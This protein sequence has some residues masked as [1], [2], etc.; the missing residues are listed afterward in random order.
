[1]RSSTSISTGFSPSMP[2]VASPEGHLAC[3]RV[4]QPSVLVVG[5]IR[6]RGRDLLNV[7]R[8]QVEHPLR[9]EPSRA[10]GNHCSNGVEAGAVLAAVGHTFRGCVAAQ[11]GDNCVSRSRTPM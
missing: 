1:M 7:E 2:V 5:L 4:D 6:E 3:P 8:V 9:V 10:S 11:L